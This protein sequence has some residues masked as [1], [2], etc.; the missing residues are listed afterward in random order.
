MKV[1]LLEDVK[2]QGKKDQVIDVSDGYAT[3]FLINKGLAVPY[4]KS[5]KTKLES[6]LKQRKENEDKLIEKAIKDKKV[7]ESIQLKF[8]VKTGN[9]G[10]IFGTI[11]S[12]QIS[13]EL[14]KKGYDIDKRDITLDHQIDFLGVHFV[15]VRLH[16]SV[17]AKVSVIVE[18]LKR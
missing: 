7:L 3:N 8:K 1:I 9:N 17:I 16:K 18:Q 5:N 11:S 14:K 12:K 10:K 15:D 4:N 2:K 13:D 6:T